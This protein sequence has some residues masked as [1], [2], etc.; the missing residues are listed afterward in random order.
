MPSKEEIKA[1]LHKSPDISDALALTFAFPVKGSQ[2]E[3]M[4]K[5]S[6]VG[7]PRKMLTTSKDR[8]MLDENKNNLERE[9]PAG[10][11]FHSFGGSEEWDPRKQS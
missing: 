10:F 2:A 9:T 6:T 4:M 5:R 11:K 7:A 1:E 3:D 8:A